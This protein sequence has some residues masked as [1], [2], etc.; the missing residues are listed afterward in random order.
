MNNQYY[1]F[2]IFRMPSNVEIKARLRDVNVVKQ[3]AENLSS[4]KGKLLKQEDIFFFVPTG[5]LKLRKIQV[6]VHLYCFC[7]VLLLFID[8]LMFNFSAKIVII[9]SDFMLVE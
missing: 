9:N 4:I 3:T 2:F 5:R 8:I 6:T 1:F 7:F